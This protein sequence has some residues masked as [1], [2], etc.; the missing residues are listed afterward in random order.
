[1]ALSDISYATRGYSN[2]RE[3]IVSQFRSKNMTVS[4]SDLHE[5]RTQLVQLM[6]RDSKTDKWT[7][8]ILEEI[9]EQP[10]FGAI[11]NFS[12]DTD[13]NRTLYAAMRLFWDVYELW[14]DGDS[15]SGSVLPAEYN[16]LFLD[17]FE[18]LYR[19]RRV[20]YIPDAYDGLDNHHELLIYLHIAAARAF[21]IRNG[22]EVSEEALDCLTEVVRTMERL[23]GGGPPT[24]FYLEAPS[25]YTSARAVVA[26]AYLE[27]WRVRKSEGRY[28]YALYYLSMAAQ[29]Y[30]GTASNFY[31]DD[32]DQIW[33]EVS[34]EE[35][36]WES[37][38]QRLLTGLDVSA[39]EAI[40]TFQVIKS[41][42]R[43]VEN[44]TQ[45]A[46]DYGGI[47]DSAMHT[48]DFAELRE[49]DADGLFAVSTQESE[50]NFDQA[51]D[52]LIVLNAEFGDDL[53]GMV[54]WG[55][56][57]HGAKTW[58]SAQLSPS[59]YR[60]M[61]EADERDAAER[62]LQTYFFGSNWS[63]LPGRAQERLIN[64]DILFNSRQ[65]V[66]LE[67]LLNDLWVATEEMCFQVIWK[68]LDRVKRG[69]WDILE[70]RKIKDELKERR[71]S[72]YPGISEYT[73][74]CRWNGY[75]EF[76]R[77][78]ETRNDDIRF[79]TKT[80]PLKMSQLRYERNSAE[81]EI[82]SLK[83]RD[84]VESFYRG[85]L[86]IGQ[87]GVLPELARIGRKLRQTHR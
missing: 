17:W 60:N 69:S 41:N 73:R 56:F 52:E 7:S 30:D 29:Y 31:G 70:F 49:N 5:W 33:P 45:V 40:K 43:S 57:W 32:I 37:R 87:A 2:I 14:K 18:H 59:E 4:E 26:M 61:R 8:G 63:Y 10:E 27:L 19:S 71:P 53:R 15:Y 3:K 48:W 11:F 39:E 72:R 51:Q 67:S 25:L 74:I 84:S 68:P 83:S 21:R 9:I 42:T 35:H 6:A 78:L 16:D 34:G 12:E 81:H 13:T 75:S 36:S 50:N 47:S 64:A 58:A 86:G 44:W 80:L 55:E 24:H 62:R 22:K 1:M 79:L 28:A 54:T 82:G 23:T 76:L 20:P 85:F 77:S 46:R 38:L 66:A 65:R